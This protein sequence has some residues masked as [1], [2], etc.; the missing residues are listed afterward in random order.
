MSKA[1]GFSKT[2]DFWEGEGGFLESGLSHI[3]EVYTRGNIGDK[4]KCPFLGAEGRAYWVGPMVA[5][6]YIARIV[7]SGNSLLTSK[8]RG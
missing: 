3:C 1:Y 8:L 5:L 4:T 2:L 7:V 6:W